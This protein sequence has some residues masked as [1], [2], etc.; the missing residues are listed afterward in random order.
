[1]KG[2]G[3]AVL[4][5]ALAAAAG[6]DKAPTEDPLFV[7]AREAVTS[8]MV[9]PESAQF[10][11]L[12]RVTLSWNGLE[13]VCG[14]YNAKNRMGGYVGFSPF[15]YGTGGALLTPSLANRR[16]NERRYELAVI[17][18]CSND[19]VEVRAVENYRGAGIHSPIGEPK[20]RPFFE[21]INQ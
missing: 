3:P 16:D 21:G 5:V 2:I 11:D 18:I 12:R 13:A 20:G 6:C 19:P 1:M 9:D 15:V 4:A 8:M 17:A 10:K 14:S 7:E